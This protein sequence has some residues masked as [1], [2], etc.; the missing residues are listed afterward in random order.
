MKLSVIINTY[1][2]YD[3]FVQ[4]LKSVQLQ[5]YPNIEIIVVNDKSTDRRYGQI[6]SDDIIWVNVE[7]SSREKFGYPCLGYCRNIGISHATGDYIAFVD[8]DDYWLPHKIQRQLEALV[9]SDCQM[10]CS[11]GMIGNGLY[12]PSQTYPI[13]HREFYA[14]YCQTFFETHYS[15]WS[16]RLPDRFDLELIQKH[17]FIIHSSVVIEKAFL[18]QVGGYKELP[19]GVEDSDLWLRCLQHTDC[20]H[21]N[22]PLLYYDGRLSERTRLGRIRKRIKRLFRRFGR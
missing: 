21:I 4:T 9:Q 17:N 16:D 8:D 18:D 22:E 14:D 15:G 7:K 1:N 10:A 19:L 20:I 11:E 2:R 3:S 5:S 12:N 13:Y 6:P